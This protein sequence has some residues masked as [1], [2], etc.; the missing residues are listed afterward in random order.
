M[1]PPIESTSLARGSTHGALEGTRGLRR[2]HTDAQLV[3][4]VQDV[5]ALMLAT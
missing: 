2:S 1:E 5:V 4:V 3:V